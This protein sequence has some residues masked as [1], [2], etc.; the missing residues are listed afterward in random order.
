[1]SYSRNMPTKEEIDEANDLIGDLTSEAGSSADSK[2]LISHLGALQHEITV[3]S[4][5]ALN[6]LQNALRHTNTSPSQTSDKGSSDTASQAT[7]E[8][9]D[10]SDISDSDS[11]SNSDDDLSSDINSEDNPD[12]PVNKEENALEIRLDTPT[13]TPQKD[14]NNNRQPSNPAANPPKPVLSIQ[15]M[16]NEPEPTRSPPQ[17]K[18][19]NTTN[20]NKPRGDTKNI[21]IPGKQ[22]ALSKNIDRYRKLLD[23][24]EAICS[25]LDSS[26]YSRQLSR[27]ND[28]LETTNIMR[29]KLNQE[30]SDT[31]SLVQRCDS[32]INTLNDM[33][34]EQNLLLSYSIKTPDVFETLKTA[35]ETLSDYF[36]NNPGSATSKQANGFA[37]SILC[38]AHNQATE[39]AHPDPQRIVAHYFE[40]QAENGTTIKAGALNHEKETEREYEKETERET[41]SKQDEKIT[42]KEYRS[43]IY[44]NPTTK[45]ALALDTVHLSSTRLGTSTLPSMSVMSWAHNALNSFLADKRATQPLQFNF[46]HLPYTCMVALV[47][48]AKM[49]GVAISR[50]SNFAGKLKLSAVKDHHV[51][52]HAKRLKE[53]IQAQGSPSKEPGEYTAKDIKEEANKLKR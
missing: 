5:L 46:P 22:A 48:Q 28:I 44:L 9:N 3:D 11:D 7:L 40:L 35:E 6:P 52:A 24:F 29:E 34:S 30:T 33:K 18:A 49:Q 41:G 36:N 13:P 10:K 17:N 39:I 23:Y 43:D 16:D 12:D 53:E 20:T 50:Y 38:K 4:S 14:P 1:M 51:A 26:A 15:P 21:N 32:I 27:V 8:G 47:I 2:N 37:G 31:S 25:K 19:S 45:D 42:I